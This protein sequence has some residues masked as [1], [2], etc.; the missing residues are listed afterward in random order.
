M[1]TDQSILPEK[2]SPLS[3]FLQGAKDTFPLI[4]GAIPF[5]IIFGTLAATAGLS[6]AATMG[7]SLFVFAGSSQFVCVSLVTAGT[8]WPMIV[9][10]TFVVNL[11]HM[12]Y[13]ATMVPFYKN[14]HPLWKMVLAFGL[15]D[16]TFAVAVTRYMQKDDAPHREYYNLGSMVFMYTNWNL[17]T[18]IGL[19]AGKTFPGIS[20]WG[21]D[22]A[23]PATFI[24]I[25]IPYLVSK[26]MWASVI[27]AGTIS[28]LA[29]GLPHKLGLMVAAIA[30]V[31]VGLVCEKFF[32]SKK[33]AA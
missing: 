8:A 29:G 30:G 28:I 13:G 6:F 26:P 11:R 25:V 19:T 1:K 31:T 3:Q 10:T 12:L 9:L 21:L 24:G 23:M 17:C 16:E 2:S 15:T 4:V 20:E 18:I 22:F 7:M 33:E 32:C 5:G 14:L 27:T